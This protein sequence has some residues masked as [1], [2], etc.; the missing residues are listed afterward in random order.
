VSCHFLLDTRSD[1]L[2][3]DRLHRALSETPA[4]EATKQALGHQIKGFIDIASTCMG[5]ALTLTTLWHTTH[6]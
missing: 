2:A 5:L 3:S 1:I 4:K 6:Q